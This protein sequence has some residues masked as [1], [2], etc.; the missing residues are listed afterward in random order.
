MSLRKRLTIIAAASV[1]VAVLLALVISY[2]VVRSQLRGQVDDSLRVQAQAVQNG[3][4]DRLRPQVP[5]IPAS[6]G[7]PAKYVQ[8]YAGSEG[9]YR[10]GNISLP[11]VAR[12]RRIANGEG[13]A[14]LSDF[15]VGDNHLREI[16]FPLQVP[17]QSGVMVTAAIQLA[18][19]LNSVDSVLSNLRLILALLFIGGIA[20]AAVLGRVASRRVLR[21]LGEVAEAARHIG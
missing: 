4:L 5:G 17:L 6:A 7:G 10:S 21:P 14:Y 18:R 2:M 9:T 16:T 8:I 1:A 3:G 20:L 12:T 15:Q 11:V 19:P 13:G